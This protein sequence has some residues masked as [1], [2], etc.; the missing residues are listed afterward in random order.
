MKK[1][2][3]GFGIGLSILLLGAVSFAFID[4]R[5]GESDFSNMINGEDGENSDGLASLLNPTE[6]YSGKESLAEHGQ[7][8]YGV[9]TE[10]EQQVYGEVYT[11]M[12]EQTDFSRVSTTDDALIGKIMEY[13]LLD[14]PELFYVESLQTQLTSVG[15]LSMMR[16]K[17]T[18]NMSKVKQKTAL[19]QIEEWEQNC[20]SPLS[21]E[22][23]D[24]EKAL[25][26]YEYVVGNI[27]YVEDAPYN[28]SLYSAVLG[29]SVCRGYANAFKYLCDEIN[30]PC[31]I[32]S[33]TLEGQGHA[34]NIVYL[35]GQW[36]HVDCTAGD[37]MS[38]TDVAVDYSWFGVSDE[39][40]NLSHLPSDTSILPVADSM[41][42]NYYYRNDLYFET[43][44]LSD[45]SSQLSTGKNFSFQCDT[46]ETYE[47]YR[48]MLSSSSEVG[49]LIGN[50]NVQ[51]IGNNNTYTLFIIF[52]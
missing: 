30:I 48:D 37:D 41:D 21:E 11:S 47:A 26:I 38:H 44:D 52:E 51:Y 34:W 32:V 45:I 22:M 17:A 46:Y 6:D 3:I 18:Q 24:Y 23:S 33:G 9:L 35:D 19:V 25:Y 4:A 13:V 43:C 20:L 1:I 42:N 39:L 50:R 12:L 31:M 5:D 15:E 49:I 7:Y 27:S 16:V 40:I 14:N 29:E 2:L 36:S 10:E 28:Q 8:Y